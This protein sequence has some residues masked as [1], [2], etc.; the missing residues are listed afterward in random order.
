MANVSRVAGFKPN[1]HLT[2]APYNGQANIYEVSAAQA[3]PLFI[4]D[5]VILDATNS[6]TSGYDTVTTACGTNTQVTS[7]N[8][9]GVV[10]GF[11]N[12]K[13][14]PD[15]KMTT[16]SVVLDVP[17]YRPASTKMF[18]LVCDSPDIILEA[19]QDVAMTLSWIGL[20]VG[21]GSLDITISG[22]ALAT[23]ASA[24]YVYATTTPTSSTTRPL[25]ILGIS[26][27]VDNDYTSANNKVYVRISTHQYA[28]AVAGA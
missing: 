9:V 24:Q 18:A 16:G 10:V 13:L 5:L 19:Q 25:Q 6:S 21:I 22:G 12:L 14:D 3:A 11:I 26:K 7:G 27:R 8:I 1:R 4:G 20:Q 28:N 15:G 23:G 17:I 2:G